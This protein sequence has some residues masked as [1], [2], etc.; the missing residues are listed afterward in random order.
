MKKFFFGSIILVLI[1]SILGWYGCAKTTTVPVI[2][3]LGSNPVYI[4][5]GT[6]YTDAGATATDA[7]DGTI[8]SNIVVK[9]SVNYNLVGTYTI[10]YDVTNKAGNAATEVVR[11]VYVSNDAANYAGVYNESTQCSSTNSAHD[12]IMVSNSVNNQISISNFGL[13][14]AATINATISSS[15]ITILK[16]TVGNHVY[17]STHG[18]ISNNSLIITYNDS[19]MGNK[20]TCTSTYTK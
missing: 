18:F 19:T 2:Y 1:I 3:L 5:L 14:P 11:T 6:V 13:N 15:T 7:T 17:W 16:Q 4:S 10:Y 20:I 8:T 9:G 12:T